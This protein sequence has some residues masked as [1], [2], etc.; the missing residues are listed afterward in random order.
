MKG[1]L[2]ESGTMFLE[3]F[4]EPS[5]TSPMIHRRRGGVG[6]GA[7]RGAAERRGRSIPG[8]RASQ[9]AMRRATSATSSVRRA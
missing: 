6:C 2:V 5:V 7:L 3:V 4:A 1:L 8:Y 9:A